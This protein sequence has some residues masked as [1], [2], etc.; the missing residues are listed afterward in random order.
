MGCGVVPFDVASGRQPTDPYGSCTEVA[1]S[2]PTKN[3][4]SGMPWLVREQL[5]D[6]VC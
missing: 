6:G 5:E 3:G 2:V 1:I 4:M